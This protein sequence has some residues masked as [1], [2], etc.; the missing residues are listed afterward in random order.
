MNVACI[1][2]KDTRDI[3]ARSDLF[4]IC[5]GFPR[6]RG[7]VVG[8]VTMLQVGRSRV[9]FPM[10]SLDFSSSVGIA[11]GYGLDDQEVGV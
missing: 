10:R 3:C 8:R 5:R 9:P 11:S 4:T 6:T 7:T 1:V 2:T